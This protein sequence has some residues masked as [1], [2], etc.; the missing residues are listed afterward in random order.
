MKTIKAQVF[1]LFPAFLIFGMLFFLSDQASAQSEGSDGVIPLSGSGFEQARSLAFSS[2]GSLLAAGAT[3]GIY[4]IDPGERSIS[5]FIETGTWARSVA[6]A[7]DRAVLAGGLFDGRIGFWDVPGAHL[8][9]EFDEPEGRVRS[10]SYSA[11]GSLFASASDDDVLRIW[12]REEETPFLQIR[13]GTDG[14]RVVALSPDGT[15]VAGAPGDNTVRVWHVPSGELLY[16]LEGH[17]DWVRCLAFSPDG[18]LLASGSFDR[19]IRLWGMA[20]GRHERI[21]EGHASSVLGVAFSPDGTR[22]AS[23]SVDETVRLWQVSDGAPLQVLQGHQDF[24]F[25]V[26]FSPDGEILASGAGD[27][28]VRL[29]ALP[30]LPE[31]ADLPVVQTPSDCRACHHSRGKVEPA[32]VIELSCEN[33]HAGGIGFSWCTGFPRSSRVV[34]GQATSYHPVEDVSGVPINDRDL[35][36]AIASPGNWETLYVG[37]QFMAPATISGK[38]FHSDPRVLPDVKVQLDIISNGET[39]A[40]LLT[41]PAENGAFSFDV[42]INPNSPPPHLSRPGTRQCLMCHGDFAPQAGLPA[43]DVHLV[44]SAVAPDGQRATDDRW[45]RID[46]SKRVTIPIHVLDAATGEGIDGLSVEASTILYE[47]RDR[48]ASTRS[49]L[50]GEAQ[51]DLESLTQANT[52][53]TVSIPPQVVNDVLY[54][55]T[56]PVDLTLE[57]GSD[58]YQPVLLTAQAVTARIQGELHLSGPTVDASIWAIQLP[59]GPA[60]R[61]SL[62]T[63]ARFAFEHIPVSQYVIVAD[64]PDAGEQGLYFEPATVDLLEMPVSNVSLSPENRRSISGQV[65]TKDGN[66][67]PFGWVHLGDTG[68]IDRIDPVT[69]GFLLTDLDS[70]TRFVTVSAPGYYSLPQSIQGSAK[71]MNI[72]LVPR[73]D[74]R[75]FDW[76]TGHVTLPSETRATVLGTNIDLESGWL[77]GEGSSPEP[78]EI[79]LPGG[80]VHIFSGQ[81]ALE[82]TAGGVG[83][84]YLQSG[85]AD[86]LYGGMQEA[87]TVQGGQMLRLAPGA[88]PLPLESAVLSALH[89]PVNQLPVPEVFE[90]SLGARLRNWLVRAGIGAMQ[91]ITFITYILSLV[92]LITIPSLALFS[93]WK[94]RRSS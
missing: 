16:T 7:P 48:Y 33:C 4:L 13:E 91:T 52:A 80:T 69:G 27:N 43:G 8:V 11:D 3:S 2:D 60:Y 77:W 68:R 42:A 90:P 46:S 81:F 55:S 76:G 36:V 18:Q 5:G 14:L 61:T 19:T 89:A 25:A 20:D 70:G 50:N 72:Q 38:V 66:R 58:T 92:T 82:R 73:P 74:L 65:T 67:V 17:T 49:T 71:T 34:V 35:A 64:V 28:T 78:L 63:N 1:L 47:W 32:R 39:T 41:N 93:I 23:G 59:A 31:K 51:L 62:Q 56:E 24:V 37:G 83:W 15:M 29:W 21:L 6:F 12:R 40:S 87:V 45:V 85:E 57:P 9:Q 54:S 26:A 53:Y 88:Q 79:H 44:I 75:V 10:I 86:V 22:L 84:F 30:S 94:R